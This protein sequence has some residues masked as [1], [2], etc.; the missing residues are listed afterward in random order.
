MTTNRVTQ[1]GYLGI[2]VS[3]VPEWE[4]FATGVLGLETNGTTPDGT[5]F[6]RMDENHHRFALHPGTRDDLAYAGWETQDDASLRAIAARL[7]S[8]GVGVTWGTAGE[9]RERGVM[10]LITLRDP[11]G[12]AIE[13]YYGALV[14][15]ERPF[16]SPRAIGGFEAGNL[17]LGHIVLSVDDY[18]ASLRFYRDG[19]GL[20]ISDYIELEMGPAGNTMAAFLHSGPRHHS[21][22]IAQF[23]APKRLH[24]FML[25]LRDMDD[26][27]NTY[28]LCQDR[29]VPIASTLGRHTN[30]HM[31]SFYLQTP[32]GFQVEYGYGGREIDDDVWEVQLHHA[33]S[34]W[35]HRSPG[36]TTPAE[37]IATA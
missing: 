13:V 12:I 29:Q 22:A 26:I 30:D 1:L 27:G 11:S 5:L 19:L 4:R 7:E 6:L 8:Q 16:H 15:F 34:I 31:L 24:H 9:A 25:Q 33:P 21:I 32:S 17:G 37:Q 2:E 23:P 20:R 36:A 28:Y 10:G 3:D 35:G 18:E 14:E